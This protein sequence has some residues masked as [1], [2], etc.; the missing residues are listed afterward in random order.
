MVEL[1][2]NKLFKEHPDFFNHP[3][4]MLL[5]LLGVLV[6]KFM[7]YQHKER[8]STPFV[9]KLKGLKLQQKDVEKLFSE[10][11]NKMIEYGIPHYWNDLKEDISNLFIASG[12]KWPLSVD[13]I[14][15]YLSV[16]M[17]LGFR[18]VFKEEDNG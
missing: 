5:V 11:N 18:S 10:L 17:A 1:H 8:Q 4:K 3:S 6:K 7:S 9:K 13:E 16:G 14:G 12:D 2:F 15:F